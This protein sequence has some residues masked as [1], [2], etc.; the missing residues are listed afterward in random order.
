MNKAIQ[1]KLTQLRNAM[2]ENGVDAYLIPRADEFQN[3]FVA[4]YAERLKY[5]TN[6]TGS[7]GLAFILTGKACLMTDAR[8]TEQAAAE[9]DT[10]LFEIVDS[11]AQSPSNWLAANAQDLIIGYDPRLH[12][13]DQITKHEEKSLTLKPLDQNLVDQIWNDQPARPNGPLTEFPDDIAGQTSAQKITTIQAQI[14]AVGADQM[15]LTLPDSIAWLLN[16]RG[17]DID[18]IPSVLRYAIVNDQGVQTY[19]QSE[20]IKAVHSLNGTTALDEKRSSIW[21]KQALSDTINLKD[22]C[23]DHK[24]IKTPQEQDAIRK[25]HI[26]DGVAMVKFLHWLEQQTDIDELGVVKKLEEFRQH[27]P[28]YKGHSFPTIAGFASNGAIIHYRPQVSTNK[29]LEPGNLLLLDSG[30]QYGVEDIW[31]T[32]DITRTIAIGEPTQEMKENN[33]RVLMGHIDLAMSKGTA[34]TTGKDL[35]NLAR[36][37]LKAADLNFAHG[38]G[39]GVGCYLAVHEEATSISP[40]ADKETMKTGMLVSNEPG[41]YKS[42]HYGIRIE[43]LILCRN[44]YSF[45]TITLCPIDQTLIIK[46]MLNAAQM[47][48][49]NIYHE[50]VKSILTPLL[51]TD[52][53]DWLK[54]KTQPL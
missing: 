26:I 9:C 39:H 51:N 3:E 8:Y 30:G 11:A 46:D 13:P 41:Y 40:R 22:P 54:E 7:A 16:K 53:Q 37:P 1:D 20:I 14:K 12:T 34:K 44:D 27:H 52:L 21:F 24:A 35:D 45:E 38:T 32:T 42:G 49:L 6:F 33:T 50:T 4:P 36:A 23:I 31:G 48:W 5:L 10:T 18:C 19:D 43:N 15:I 29:K 47:E 28:A 25:A 17:N 2:Q